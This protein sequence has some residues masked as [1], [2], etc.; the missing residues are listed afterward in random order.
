[1]NTPKQT[2]ENDDAVYWYC[3]QVRNHEHILSCIEASRHNSLFDHPPPPEVPKTFWNAMHQPEWAAAID[4]EHKKTEYCTFLFAN[5][6]SPPTRQPLQ[7]D[8]LPSNTATP[9]L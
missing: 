6:Y 3:T 5:N 2:I 7:L 9:I 1:M 8:N 4:T